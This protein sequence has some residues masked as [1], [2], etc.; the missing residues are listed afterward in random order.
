MPANTPIAVQPLDEEGRAVQVMRSWFTAMPGERVSCVGCHEPQNSGPPVGPSLAARRAPTPIEPWY[1]PARGFSFKREVQPVLD[2]HCVG[3]HDGSSEDVLDLRRKERQGWRNFTPSY[4]A[5]HPFVR[6]PGPESDYHLQRPME[7]HASTS[8]LIQMLKRGHYGVE[9][10]AEGWDRLYTWIDL[11]V[12]DHGTWGEHAPIPGDGQARRLQMLAEHAGRTDDPEKIP[13]LRAAPVEFVAPKPLPAKASVAP[14]VPGWPFDEPEAL[15][16]RDASG[17]EQERV[18]ELGAGV[19]LRLVAIPAGEFVMFDGEEGPRRGM[20][21]ERPFWMG[22]LEVTREQFN[23]FDPEHHNGYLNQNHKD[24]TKP[25]YFANAPKHPVIR[26]SW[27]EAEAFCQWLGERSGLDVRLPTEAEW[28]W[29]CRAGSATPFYFGG[30]DSDFSGFANLADASTR[31]LAVTGIDPKPI[32]SPSRFEDWLPKD[33]RFDDGQRIMCETGRYAPNAWGLHDMHG[34]VSEWTSSDDGREG[35][36]VIR[37]G[38]WRDRPKNA[39]Q[40]W[41]YR[42][43]QPVYNVGFRVI[44]RPRGTR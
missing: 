29:A 10:D 43:W 20:R 13:E 3:C 39:G 14:V 23:R 37:G 1:G 35:F 34:N 40:R 24:H 41:S 33:A 26:V 11:N 36:R 21:I 7:W 5:L 4:I 25:G 16:R 38:S 12:P 17:L 15:R 31:R 22:A 18:L 28:E 32:P 8:E 42:R 27:D 6:R 9:L 44:A 19:K 2:R 30:Y